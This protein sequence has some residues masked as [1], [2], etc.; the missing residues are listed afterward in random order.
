MAAVIRKDLVGWVTDSSGLR[1]ILRANRARYK[2][3]RRELSDVMKEI[4]RLKRLRQTPSQRLLDMRSG[5]LRRTS[6]SRRGL[7]EAIRAVE[8]HLGVPARPF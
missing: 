5:A 3:A 2:V 6:A 7:I 1:A 8:T 4:G